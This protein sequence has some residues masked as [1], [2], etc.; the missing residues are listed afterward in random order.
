MKKVTKNSTVFIVAQR[1]STIMSADKIIVLDEGR[2]AGINLK[3]LKQ[4]QI[5][6]LR[7]KL[8]VVFQDFQLLYDRNVYENLRFVLK[9]TGWKNEAQ[10]EHRIKELL[11]HV[12]LAHK[13]HKMPYQTSP[14]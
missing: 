9:A 6:Y 12:D 1:I 13:I 11:N 2:V 4:S 14:F 3:N 5:P 8:G 10:I 7:R